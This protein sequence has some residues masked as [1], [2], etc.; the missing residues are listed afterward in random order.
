MLLIQTLIYL[1]K[2]KKKLV[3][4]SCGILLKKWPYCFLWFYF[5]F[6]HVCTF[7]LTGSIYVKRGSTDLRFSACKQ[8]V[9]SFWSLFLMAFFLSNGCRYLLN[10]LAMRSSSAF[11]DDSLLS[12]LCY[13]FNSISL[14]FILTQR[15]PT[16]GLR[17][18][19]ISENKNGSRNERIE[20]LFPWEWF[21]L[22]I[23]IWK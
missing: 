19:G 9:S 6:F 12:Y 4:Y 16:W 1:S 15:V 17:I 3:I 8:S 21:L 10:L 14:L 11:I 22:A 20:V 5:Y 7:V 2:K 23:L 18:L 13:A